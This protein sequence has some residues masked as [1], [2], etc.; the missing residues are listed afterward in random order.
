MRRRDFITLLGGAATWPLTVRAQQPAIPVIGFLHPASK[1]AYEDMLAAFSQGLKEIGYVEGQNVTI[2]YRWAEGRYDRLPAMAVELIDRPVVVLVA[3][4]FPAALAAKAST[5]T[6]PIVF[7]SGADPVQ[8][9]L[10][11]SLNRPGGNMTG[12][13]LL[14]IGL[15][16]KRLELLQE[17]VPKAE[18]IG[19]LVNP[20]NPKNRER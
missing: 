19:L 9:G 2:E 15:L 4:A 17:L 13:S 7:L 12:M 3:G 16:A 18:S 14:M 6:T 10:V 8:A 1:A 11:A 20:N 5:S